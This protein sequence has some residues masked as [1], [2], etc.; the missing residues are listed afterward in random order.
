[1][2]KGIQSLAN[3][4]IEV[5]SLISSQFSQSE[6]DIKSLGTRFDVQLN[7]EKESARKIS[8]ALEEKIMSLQLELVKISENVEKATRA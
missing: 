2:I 7:T 5:K 6:T 4:L 1:M 8:T 3:E